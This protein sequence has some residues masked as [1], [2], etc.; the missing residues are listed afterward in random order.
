MAPFPDTVSLNGED[1]RGRGGARGRG[2]VRAR[3][4][5]RTTTRAA[6]LHPHPHPLY[7]HPELAHHDM[8]Q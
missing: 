3:G 6:S 5:R 7:H 8:P 1:Y 2:A 4:A